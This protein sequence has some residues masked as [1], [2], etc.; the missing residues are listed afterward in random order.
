[1]NKNHFMTFVKVINRYFTN[2]YLIRRCDIFFKRFCDSCSLKLDY[3]S[4]LFIYISRDALRNFC[5]LYILCG[6]KFGSK[7]ERRGIFICHFEVEIFF[8]L[9]LRN[10][11][12][13]RS[14][15]SLYLNASKKI[16]EMEIVSSS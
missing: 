7:H 1:M 4:Y 12:Y 2:Q 9:I 11:P 10:R 8:F 5:N 3:M 16:L 6:K 13:L 14:T 15:Y